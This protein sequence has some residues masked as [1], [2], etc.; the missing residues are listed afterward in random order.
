LLA[1]GIS[2]EAYIFGGAVSRGIHARN[3]GRVVLEGDVLVE[4]GM[5]ITAEVGSVVD[6]RN[7][8]LGD[9]YVDGTQL[10]SHHV[11]GL[12]T[13]QVSSADGAVISACGPPPDTEGNHR[14]VGVA[15]AA[16]LGNR[17]R[18]VPERMGEC[19][20]RVRG[21]A[22]DPQVD[23][24]LEADSGDPRDDLALQVVLLPRATRE[25]GQHDAAIEIVVNEAPIREAIMGKSHF[26]S[27]NTIDLVVSCPFPLGNPT[28]SA[29]KAAGVAGRFD[30]CGYARAWLVDG[31]GWVTEL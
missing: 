11:G 17:H 23:V 10:L 1:G 31:A 30:R 3:G 14:F 29:L 15:V 9:R 18:V 12:T 6:A 25:L 24:F 5:L 19:G 28:R 22:L 13:T 4:K 27:K 26:A 21:G 8:Y 16:F 7:A 2:G 20:A